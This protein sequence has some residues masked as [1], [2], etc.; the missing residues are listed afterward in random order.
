MTLITNSVYEQSLTV[1]CM[2]SGLL[3][4]VN[5]SRTFTPRRPAL[6]FLRPLPALL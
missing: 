4:K 2:D 3:L 5:L 6:K 1:G